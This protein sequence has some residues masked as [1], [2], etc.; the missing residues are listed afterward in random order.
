MTAAHMRTVLLL[1]A[2]A[3]GLALTAAAPRRG[4][5]QGDPAVLGQWSEVKPWPIVA[6]H[7]HV[8]PNGRVLVWPR[9][10]GEDAR[11]W[12]PASEGFTPVPL[13]TTNLFCSGHAFLPDGRLLVTGGHIVD[14]VGPPDV[15][16]FDY[17]KNRWKAATPM[18]AGRWY[19]TSCALGNGEVLVLSGITTPEKG[20]DALPQVFTAR[21]VWRNL[22]SAQLVLPLYPFVHLA[23][24]GKVFNSGPNRDTRYLDSAGTGAWTDVAART[25]YRDYGSSV[26]YDDGKVLLA[27]GG[28]PPT[29]TAEVIDLNAGAPAWRSVSPMAFARRQMN[30]TL[31]PDGKV[32]VT[33]GTSSGTFNDAAG[34]VLDAELWDPDTETF[35]TVAPQEIRRLYHSTAVLLPDGRVLSGGGGQPFATGESGNHPDVQIYSP[36][37]LFN[38]PRP[39]I[40]NAPQAVKY[41][42]KFVVQTRDAAAIRRVTWVRLSS[43]THSVN[44]NQRINRL[45]FRTVPRGLQ[46]TAPTN[47]NVCPPGHHML[48]I[49]NAAGVPSEAAI[50]QIR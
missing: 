30:A 16:I 49:L 27:G 15:N 17:R 42:K 22:T 18:N 9:S 23:P 46:V 35:S 47:P 2:T 50:V 25:I 13:S 36:P 26:M 12:D 11:I 44:M 7:T 10:G 14:G 41:G 37:Y 34:A 31:L 40:K 24:N 5:A 33:G 8:L 28:D 38:G 29:A 21:G 39:V 4:A 20:I 43:V 45:S 19:P 6:I 1:A 48:F 32:L 3:V